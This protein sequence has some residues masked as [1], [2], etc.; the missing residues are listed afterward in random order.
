MNFS[1]FS[2]PDSYSFISLAHIVL[3]HLIFMDIVFIFLLL[4]DLSR[5]LSLAFAHG[6]AMLYYRWYDSEAIKVIDYL[7][8]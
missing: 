2:V 6:E 1:H 5:S 3:L 8:L 4:R 7:L